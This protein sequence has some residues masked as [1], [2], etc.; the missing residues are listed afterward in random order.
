MHWNSDVVEGNVNRLK[1]IKRQLYGR[2]AFPCSASASSTRV[3]RALDL[4]D[5]TDIESQDPVSPL[6]DISRVIQ[7]PDL[8]WKLYDSFGAPE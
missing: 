3:Q 8:L 1:T 7:C 2:A 5:D 4:M 6:L